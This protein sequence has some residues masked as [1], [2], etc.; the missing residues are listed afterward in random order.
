MK[1]TLSTLLTVLLIAPAALLAS[2]LSVKEAQLVERCER[3]ISMQKVEAAQSTLNGLAMLVDERKK[4][5]YSKDFLENF[6]RETKRCA[7]FAYGAGAGF[8]PNIAK[9]QTEEGA[10]E[11]SET[12]ERRAL[13]ARLA[14]EA[15]AQV[16][17]EE[18][19][20]RE[21]AQDLRLDVYTRVYKACSALV[22]R[23]EVLAYTN[24]LCVESF[25]ANGLPE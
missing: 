19:R 9:F 6:A 12:K 10:L 18:R 22:D 11:Y 5:D 4:G 1:Y 2:G 24:K 7:E 16:E 23:D 25:L 21:Q 13:E 20:R 8:H 15:Q 14:R 3:Y 17:T